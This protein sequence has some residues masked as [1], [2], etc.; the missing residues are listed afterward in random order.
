MTSRCWRPVVLLTILEQHGVVGP[1]LADRLR[2]LSGFRNIAVHDYQTLDP[3]ILEAIVASRLTDLEEFAEA[4]KI[5]ARDAG[6][7]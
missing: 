1:D 5:A 2:R 4:V 7:R 3:A 6:K